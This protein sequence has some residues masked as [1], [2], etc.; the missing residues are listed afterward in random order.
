METVPK[1]NR[2]TNRHNADVYLESKL[3]LQIWH[4]AVVVR[5]AAAHRVRVPLQ[6][7]VWGVRW[8][9]VTL[10]QIHICIEQANVIYIP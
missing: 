10:V 8:Q 7:K 4:N 9:V 1:I 2:F 3:F 6:A 5:R